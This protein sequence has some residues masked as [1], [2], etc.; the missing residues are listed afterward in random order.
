MNRRS[1][2]DWHRAMVLLE[3]HGI[4]FSAPERY[5]GWPQDIADSCV[6][7]LQSDESDELPVFGTGSVQ[8]CIQVIDLKHEK[9]DSKNVC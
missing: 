2:V 8:L 3:Q 5:S 9:I 6:A 7:I 1:T 4:Q